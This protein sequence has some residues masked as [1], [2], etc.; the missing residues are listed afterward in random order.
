MDYFSE[1]A[2]DRDV[3]A[4][5]RPEPSRDAGFLRHLA[6]RAHFGR[7]AG[8]ELSSRDLPHEILDRAPGL[9]HE[10]YAAG[11]V[12]GPHCGR[13]RMTHEIGL[14][15]APV[16]IAKRFGRHCDYATAVYRVAGGR[17]WFQHC[18]PHESYGETSL[19]ADH[20]PRESRQRQDDA[21]AALGSALVGAGLVQG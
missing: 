6:H 20:H 11:I 15:F 12:E 14:V 13:A 21:R 1:Y 9:A 10:A 18:V 16:R 8:A 17:R 3:Q 5:R 19:A 4:E 7:L 2:G